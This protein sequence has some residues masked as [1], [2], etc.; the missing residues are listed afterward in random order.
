MASSPLKFY[1]NN[2]TLKPTMF[3]FKNYSLKYLCL[4]VPSQSKG[5]SASLTLAFKPKAATAASK[6]KFSS[7]GNLDEEYCLR[8]S[9]VEFPDPRQSLKI[10][11]KLIKFDHGILTKYGKKKFHVFTRCIQ[12]IKYK[13]RKHNRKECVSSRSEHTVPQLSSSLSDHCQFVGS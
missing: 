7:D 1:L 11:N 10:T 4:R 2:C 12:S 9:C 6:H 13:A 8:L 5:W 3:Y